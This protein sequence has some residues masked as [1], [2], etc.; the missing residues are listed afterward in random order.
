MV[1][2]GVDQ[3]MHHKCSCNRRMR[4][5]MPEPIKVAIEISNKVTVSSHTLRQAGNLLQ[6]NR[7]DNYTLRYTNN[8][9]KHLTPLR[10]NT[11]IIDIPLIC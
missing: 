4:K 8:L 7:Y 1:M 5:P 11:S 6:G 10:D 2:N 3:S 9:S